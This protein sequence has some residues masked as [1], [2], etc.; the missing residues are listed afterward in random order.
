MKNSFK[1]VGSLTFS[2]WGLLHELF[3]DLGLDVADRL[4]IKRRFAAEG[5]AF[6]TKILPLYSKKLLRSLDAGRLV[7]CEEPMLTSFK[8]EGR[9]PLLF[10]GYLR[11]IFDLTTGALLESPSAAAVWIIRQ[12]CEYV[13]K[14]AVPFSLDEKSRAATAFLETDA[15]VGQ[16]IDLN[17][18]EQ[19]RKDLH[20]YYPSIANAHPHTVF[21]RFSPRP[22]SGTYA[23]SRRRAPGQKPWYVRRYEECLPRPSDAAFLGFFLPWRGFRARRFSN[24][25]VYRPDGN[26]VESLQ[27]VSRKV[28]FR[29]PFRKDTS[30]ISEVLF[31]PKDSRGP[32]TIVREPYRALSIQMAFHDWLKAELETATRRRVNFQDQT[33]NRELARKSSVEGDYA[34]LDLK[35]ASD[36]V[37][38][39][40]WRRIARHSPALRWVLTH[41]RTSRARLPVECGGHVVEL[42]KLAGMG[43]GLTFPLMSLL[44]TLSIVRGVVN[45]HGVSYDGAKKLIY[46]YGDDIVLPTQW[47][48]TA[49]RSLE[50][51]GLC[52]NRDKSFWKGPFRESCGGDFLRGIDVAPVRLKLASANPKWSRQ[53]REISTAHESGALGAISIDRHARELAKAGLRR[54]ASFLWDCLEQSLGCRLPYV[55]GESAL[56]GRWEEYLSTRPMDPDGTCATIVALVP[57]P[58]K[59]QFE[60]GLRQ[61]GLALGG[62]HRDS[63][64]CRAWYG[65]R[66]ELLLLSDREVCDAESRIFGGRI[67]KPRS[68]ILRWRVISSAALGW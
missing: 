35:D 29:N 37:S 39:Q 62:E 55:T 4:I 20:T 3:N 8:M 51:V 56:L 47:V 44:I 34:T 48:E 26:T 65:A 11:E 2:L 14:L 32:R 45:D 5:L 53:S 1:K 38:Y 36:S 9:A 31:V 54:A 66:S 21:E 33:I 58:L 15:R 18:V 40:I 16:S 22:G 24:V 43:S 64:G 30:A 67:S 13:Y 28:R 52:V 12:V 23:D 17:Y 7:F 19:L 6:V 60:P 61:L 10:R 63:E 57:G 68:A 25:A 41:A 59:T 50:R 42:N 46:V 27:P 49:I